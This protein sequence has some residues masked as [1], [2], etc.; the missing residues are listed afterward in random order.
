MNPDFI[1]LM[2]MAGDLKLSHKKSH[3]GIT[4]STKELVLHKPHANYYLS[5]EDIVSITP[6]ESGKLLPFRLVNKQ[7]TRQEIVSAGDGTPHYNVYVKN[8]T[9]HNRSG[10]FKLGTM[11]FIIPIHRDLIKAIGRFGGWD[12]AIDP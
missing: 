10:V 4:V 7:E 2:P 12:V 8:A 9:L 11:Q 5:F 6:C 3:F 1:R